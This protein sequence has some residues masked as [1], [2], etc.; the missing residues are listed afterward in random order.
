MKPNLVIVQGD[1]TSAVAGAAAAFYKGIPVAHVE[2]GLRSGNLEKPFPE[3]MNR[4]VISR[5]SKLHF[6]PT[7]LAR[8]NLLE[9]GI[10][11]KNIFLVGNTI[12]DTLRI[13]T[14]GETFKANTNC[15]NTLLVTLHRR[16]NFKVGIKTVCRALNSFAEKNKNV[17][18]LFVQHSNPQTAKTARK[19]LN[20]S[21]NIRI[22]RQLTHSEIIKLMVNAK[23]ILTDS[24]GIQ[25]EAY[26]LNKKVLIARTE[27]ERPE[28]LKGDA[29]LLDLKEDAILR[30]L[31]LA[32]STNVKKK[33]KILLTREI[34][35]LNSDLGDGYASERI[36]EEIRR[37][38]ESTLD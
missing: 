1:T 16:E 30:D 27:T 15:E 35:N 36:M 12:V 18:V 28:V 29:K 22:I 11:N 33:T 4:Q 10:K 26:L 8:E 32:F 6:V 23:C 17:K 13:Q 7:K 3:E 21:K 38:L 14:S 19:A 25:E 37:Y 34:L 5:Y 31:E 9:E 20:T 2:A 24:G